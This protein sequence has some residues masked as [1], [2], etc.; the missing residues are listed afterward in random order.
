MAAVLAMAEVRLYS[1]GYSM[2]A[3]V[4]E[5]APQHEQVH[6]LLCRWGAWASTRSSAGRSLASVEGLYRRAGT[7]PATAPLA[8]DKAILAVERALIGMPNEQE[9]TLR[10]LYVYRMT[11]LAI[12]KMMRPPLRY[13]AWPGHVFVCRAMVINRIRFN[14]S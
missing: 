2:R 3:P 13:E 6:A 7:A 14:E 4:D 11:P 9:T 12:C 1:R 10:R 8:A 5:I